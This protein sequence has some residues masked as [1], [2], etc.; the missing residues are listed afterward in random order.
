MGFAGN[1]QL[2]AIAYLAKTSCRV[3]S[4]VNK[5]LLFNAP[6]LDIGRALSS[7]RSWSSKTS[8]LA[9]MGDGDAKRG[10]ATARCHRRDEQRALVVLA[11][12]TFSS[13]GKM[14]HSS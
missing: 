4:V 6:S 7:A 3:R 5:V 9:A 11:S 13:E 10:L 1:R 12:N 14:H 2:S 8:P